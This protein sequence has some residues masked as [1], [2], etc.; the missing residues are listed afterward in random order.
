MS[1]KTRLKALE[2]YAP[3]IT[4][5]V[6]VYGEVGDTSDQAVER[7]LAENGPDSIEDEDKLIVVMF[8]KPEPQHDED[9]PPMEAE[10]TVHRAKNT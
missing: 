2:K 8:I 6:V 5:F 4:N 1:V 10:E 9:N 7:Y 3:A